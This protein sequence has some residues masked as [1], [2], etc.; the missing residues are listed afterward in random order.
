MRDFATSQIARGETLQFPSLVST[1][2]KCRSLRILAGGFS[3]PFNCR[4]TFSILGFMLRFS[5]P[6]I[7]FQ[8]AIGTGRWLFQSEIAV[9][10]APSPCAEDIEPLSS[11]PALCVRVNLNS[12][13]NHIRNKA[14]KSPPKL[15][16][17]VQAATDSSHFI[18]PRMAP[19]PLLGP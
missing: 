3:D 2:L 13:R 12:K 6:L 8:L 16:I 15:C 11:L 19:Q 14:L 1:P 10:V 18:R 9:P 4:F 17:F 5:Y 7:V